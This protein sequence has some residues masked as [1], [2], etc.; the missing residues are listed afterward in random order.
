M[1]KN[2]Y[3][4]IVFKILV[5]LYAV[6]KHEII[7]DL[8]TF[9]K[10]IKYEDINEQYFNS[11]LDMMHKDGYIDGVVIAKAWGNDLIVASDLKDMYITSNGIHYLKENDIMNKIKNL[12]TNNVELIS[13]LIVKVL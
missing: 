6:L 2:D 11:I 1:A 8:I 3:D 10:A 7:F 9:K 5:Y 12:L 4:V 13:S